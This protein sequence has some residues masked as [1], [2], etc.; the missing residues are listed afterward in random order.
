MQA[1]TRPYIENKT[2]THSLQQPAQE[3]SLRS[4][5]QTCRKL[6]SCHSLPTSPGSQTIIP[7]TTDTQW[8]G[9][10]KTNSF[11]NFCPVSSLRSFP[12]GSD[13]NGNRLQF[14]RPGFD[15]WVGK[16]PWRRKW[17]PTPVILPGKFHGWRNLIGY[18]PWGCKESDT[19]ERLHFLA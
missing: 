2:L 8:T 11:P 13:G 17:Q 14:E 10:D 7:I 18:S 1:M 19:T 3:V 16:I 5:N 4:T 12:G 15:P 9:P 6:A